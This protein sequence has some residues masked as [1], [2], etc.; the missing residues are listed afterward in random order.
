MKRAFADL[1]LRAENSNNEQL[2]KLVRKSAELG[3]TTVALSFPPATNAEEVHRIKTVCSDVNLDLVSRVDIRPRSP[4]D[5]LGLLRK[6]RRKFEVICVLCESKEIAR[7]AAKDRRVDLLNFPSLDYRKRFFDRA[8]AELASSGSATLEVDIKP[9]LVLE[10][11]PR[12]RFLSTLRREVSVALSFRLPIVI[13]SG[14]SDAITLRRPK[15]T[16][17][18]ASL[19]GLVGPPALDA[20]SSNPLALVARNREK[21]SAGFIAPGIRLVKRGDER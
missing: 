17:L 14:A 19:F 21:L 4:E 12:V 8:E 10:G 9:V 2:S 5:L 7:Q 13:S 16:A 15:E 18:L 1:H 3:Y 6:L 11:A 20:V